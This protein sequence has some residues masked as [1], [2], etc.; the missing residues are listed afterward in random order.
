MKLLFALLLCFL[1]VCL[2][3]V[4]YG[5]LN[6]ILVVLCTFLFVSVS[7]HTIQILNYDHHFVMYCAGRGERRDG[8]QVE[9]F[10]F[11]CESKTNRDSITSM[12]VRL[13]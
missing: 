3:G 6:F 8:E 7:P 9:Y 2:G 5:L 11:S 12:G 4:C 13:D 1:Q 10:S